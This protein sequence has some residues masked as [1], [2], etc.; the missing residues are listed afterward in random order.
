MLIGYDKLE[1]LEFEKD[2]HLYSK[3]DDNFILAPWVSLANNNRLDLI[4]NNCKGK[5]TILNWCWSVPAVVDKILNC[6]FD[7]VFCVSN[8]NS[9]PIRQ[10][11]FPFY[12]NE[13]VHLSN[14][15]KL[16]SF[17]GWSNNPIRDKIF[18]FY[19]ANGVIRRDSFHYNSKEM[20]RNKEEYAKIL[21]ASRFSFCPRGKSSGTFRLWESFRA[22]AIPIIISDEYDS[23]KHELFE[24]AVIKVPENRFLK[25]PYLLEAEIVKIS[26]EGEIKRRK[27]CLKIDEDFRDPDYIKYYTSRCLEN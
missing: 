20:Q 2:T 26:A 9:V 11:T 17:V 6:G 18:E 12:I 22:G 3:L 5:Y 14:K 21:A 24:R 10:F 16:Y 1:P 23:P 15:N 7:A 19:K 4:P 27:K 25:F 13:S 8:N